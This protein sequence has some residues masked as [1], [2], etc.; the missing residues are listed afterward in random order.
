MLIITAISNEKTNALTIYGTLFQKVTI[1]Y[2][3]ELPSLLQVQE[4]LKPC[5]SSKLNFSSSCFSADDSNAKIVWLH[6]VIL[7][8]HGFLYF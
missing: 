1:F 6:V 8:K 2:S 7:S 3:Q 4:K 5:K